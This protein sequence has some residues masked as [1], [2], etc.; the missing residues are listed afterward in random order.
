VQKVLGSEKQHRKQIPIHLKWIKKI[1]LAIK[2]NMGWPFL[3]G[4][5]KLILVITVQEIHCSPW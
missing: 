5:N 4:E 3:F 2:E 1:L